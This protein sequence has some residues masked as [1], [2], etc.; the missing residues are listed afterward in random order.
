MGQPTR[1]H[2]RVSHAEYIGMGGDTRGSETSQYPEEKKS[3]EIPQV[4]ASERGSAKTR[5][6]A[7][8][9]CGTRTWGLVAA[10]GSNWNAAR[11]RVKAPYPK[12]KATPRVSLVG[13][14]T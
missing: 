11:Y 7:P 9:G 4:A 6:L 13:R 8:W 12:A 5:A 1:S 3:N 2:Q 14:N 10:R